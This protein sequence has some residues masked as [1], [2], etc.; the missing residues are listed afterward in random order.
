MG[1]RSAAHRHCFGLSSW[2]FIHPLSLRHDRPP[3]FRNEWGN[4]LSKPQYQAMMDYSPYETFREPIDLPATL[5]WTGLQDTRVQFYE[6]TKWVAKLKTV[7]RNS[8]RCPPTGSNNH[9]QDDQDTTTS[10]NA[11][12][13]AATPLLL[14]VDSFGHFGGGERWRSDAFLY[15]FLLRHLNDE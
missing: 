9:D 15:A 12:T 14:R 13:A 8:P 4:P 5:V 11:K 2:S 1:W 3:V 10:S 7:K 6:P